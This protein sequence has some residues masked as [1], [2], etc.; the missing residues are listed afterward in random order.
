MDVPQYVDQAEDAGA[1]A[2]GEIKF[3]GGEVSIYE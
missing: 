1:A 2:G 3:R